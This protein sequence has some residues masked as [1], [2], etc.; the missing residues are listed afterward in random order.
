MSGGRIETNEE[1]ELTHPT[2][3]PR[4]NGR[5]PPMTGPEGGPV[6]PPNPDAP[7]ITSPLTLAGRSVKRSLL[8]SPRRRPARRSPA[9]LQPICQLGQVSTLQ[10]VRSPAC[11]PPPSATG[12]N[13][14]PGH[15]GPAVISRPMNMISLPS[16]CL[17]QPRPNPCLRL[18][19]AHLEH[20]TCRLGPWPRRTT[21][22]RTRSPG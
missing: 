2:A 20:A 12:F 13:Q 21:G 15:N 7:G 19:L 8:R 18:I 4:I 10:P 16:R 9:T 6:T 5:F 14:F 22:L 1:V 3:N 11:Q 17:I